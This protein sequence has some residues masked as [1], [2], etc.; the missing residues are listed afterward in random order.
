MA[1]QALAIPEVEPNDTEREAK[2]PLLRGQSWEGTSGTENDEDTWSVNVGR[3][4][5]QV[6]IDFHNTTPLPDTQIFDFNFAIPI[7]F[8][9]R[10]SCC[11]ITRRIKHGDRGQL[12]YSLRGPG[13]YYFGVDAPTYGDSPSYRF[14]VRANRPLLG[15]R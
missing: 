11:L 4:T 2:R 12:R 15:R 9:E 3:G 6:A 8:R 14:A 10:G 1:P 7:Y 5:T 13:R